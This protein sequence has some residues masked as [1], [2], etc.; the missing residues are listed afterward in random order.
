[1]PEIR[2]TA[3]GSRADNGDFSLDPV[4]KSG[5]QILRSVLMS[6]QSE[7]KASINQIL[8]DVRIHVIGAKRRSLGIV[9]PD[10]HTQAV[11]K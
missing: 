6:V 9:V 8:Y 4:P 1:M 5:V 10:G 11:G 7:A 2:T 3:K